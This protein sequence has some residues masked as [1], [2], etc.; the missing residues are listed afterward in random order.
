[1]TRVTVVV[2]AYN[3]GA[4]F[5]A[6]LATLADYFAMHRAGGYSFDYLVVDDGSTDETLR[7]ATEFAR[8]RDDVRIVKHE[9]NR[10][11][12]AALRTAFERV[13]SD[14]VVV[15]DADLSYSPSTAM[16]LVER[17]DC[18]DADVALAS[19]Y[20]FGGTVEN[21]PFGRRVMSREAN[22]VLSF[23][24]AGRYAT[25]TCM[26]RAFRASAI[27]RL[28]FRN[29]GMESI[30]EMLLSAL[31]QGMKVVEVPATLR[32]S[33]Q[34]REVGGRLRIWGLPKRIGATF[35]MACRHRPSLWLAVPGLFPG[36]LPLVV[37]VLFLLHVRGAALAGGTIATIV[38][39]YSSLAFF[40]GQ[41]TM[42]FGRRLSQRHRG[43]TTHGYDLPSRTT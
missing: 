19:P 34:R 33:D 10:G 9:H 7:S 36:L 18:E 4:A 26:V 6:T 28:V 43:V 37:G 13:S 40:S 35:G 27:P 16:Q 22:R 29:D 24:T 2:P 14:V 30:P 5:G 39:Q 21:V 41:I 3:E 23:A 11:L 17:L 1:M 15:V 31:R 25:L 8:W 32:W 42:F 12:G 38:V 20:A